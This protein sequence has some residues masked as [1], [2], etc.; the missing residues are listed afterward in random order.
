IFTQY[1]R[2]GSVAAL[3]RYLDERRIRSVARISGAGRSYGGQAYS[4]GALYQLLKNAVYI[5]R[6]VHRGESFAGQHEAIIEPEVWTQV[7]T[8]LADNN[9]SHRSPGRKSSP[10]LLTGLLFDGQGNRYTPTHAVK[11]GKRYRYY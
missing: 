4:R 10:S 9:R 8:L 5:G 3:K 11:S 1:L 6:I 2:L 7:S